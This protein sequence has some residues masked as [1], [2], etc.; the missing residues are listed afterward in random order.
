MATTAT[1]A[2]GAQVTVNVFDGTRQ[3]Y[4]D[5]ANQILYTVRDGNQ[6]IV[7]RDYRASPSVNF[8]ALEV[9][10][11]FG[12]DYTF[13]VSASGYKDAGF[14]PV[15]VSRNTTPVVDLM[16][17]PAS[18]RFNFADASWRQVGAALPDLK[19]ALS[20]GSVGDA[21][22]AVRYDDLKERGGGEV[23]ACL[24][25]ITTAMSQFHLP[26]GTALSYLKG[27][28]WDSTGDNA[29]ARDRFY[30]WADPAVIHQLDQAKRQKTVVDAPF[31]L[32]PG[33]TRS[34][35]Q[36]E[37]GEANVQLTFHEGSINAINSLGCVMVEPDIDYYK[38]AGAHLLLEV[39]VNTFGHLTDPRAV[40][41]LRWIAGQRA[42]FPQFDP[43]YTIVKD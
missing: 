28:V 9:F 11:N 25:N 26:H 43:L 41:V 34:Y 2:L 3:P 23:L 20:Q 5:A 14:H 1:A 21:A 29:M 12:D 27:I 32:H 33:A 15:K 16:L 10:E 18:N 40:Y 7:S 17:L 31:G 13:L 6:R 22:A 38:D 8:T 39:A 35:K 36:V 4:S 30:G 24:L 42:G 37:F 19:S